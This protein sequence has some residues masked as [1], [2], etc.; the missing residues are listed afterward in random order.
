MTR[1]LIVRL[2][3]G[4]ALL[5]FVL[6]ALWL[7]GVP[8]TILVMIVL[9]VGTLELNLIV[10][11]KRIR[12]S[13]AFSLGIVSA[14]GL[15]RPLGGEPE[16]AVWFGVVALLA[17]L[18]ALVY[19]ESKS[20]RDA[21]VTALGTAYIAFA[22]YFALVLRELPN[23]LIYW[24]LV[25]I[26]TSGMDTFSYIGGRLFGKHRLAPHISPGKTVE[27]AV[28]GG[29]CCVVIALAFLAAASTLTPV[30]VII[31]LSMPFADVAG[32]LLESW[33]KRLY[34]VKDSYIPWLNIFPGHGGVLDRVDG[35]LMV[36]LIATGILALAGM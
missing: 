24:A 23:G 14:I 16:R 7:G 15:L 1:N 13:A 18:F 3:T 25:F 32:D 21:L 29:V 6:M 35:L 17:L 27:G 11:H 12:P 19:W 4:A 33:A 34:N 28:I 2:V 31:T 36:I 22:A 10:S 20:A 26:G 5:P 30:A 8:F 9:L